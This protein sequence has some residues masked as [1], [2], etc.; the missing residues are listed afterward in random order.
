VGVTSLATQRVT[1]TP[2]GTKGPADVIGSGGV[3]SVTDDSFRTGP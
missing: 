3:I 2:P 1:F